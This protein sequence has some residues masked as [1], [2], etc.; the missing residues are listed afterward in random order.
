MKLAACLPVHLSVYHFYASVCLF[1][2][3]F[4]SV[5][6]FFRRSVSAH[7]S[8]K[9]RVCLCA[10]RLSILC[11]SCIYIHKYIFS[12]S[13]SSTPVGTNYFCCLYIRRSIL[14]IAHIFGKKS[15]IIWKNK[16]LHYNCIFNFITT[17]FQLDA[18][19]D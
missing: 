19:E 4:V 2:C 6:L 14:V 8:V 11:T 5:F 7:L 18:S 9:L 3:L 16:H 10:F 13:C 12:L 15:L 17:S 1:I